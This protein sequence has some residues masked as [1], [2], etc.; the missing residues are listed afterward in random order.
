MAAICCHGVSSGTSSQA[1]RVPL[2]QSS[3]PC[4]ESMS[5]WGSQQEADCAGVLREQHPVPDQP[6]VV[7]G[8]DARL[9]SRD[10]VLKL[11]V[12]PTQHQKLL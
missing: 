1:I 4:D 3:G 10:V 5:G 6:Q 8:D 7:H 12:N 2:L 11:L 9:P